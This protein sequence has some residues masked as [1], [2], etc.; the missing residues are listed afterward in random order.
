MTQVAE[1]RNSLSEHRDSLLRSAKDAQ[2]RA[3]TTLCE[4]I[5]GETELPAEMLPEVIAATGWTIDHVTQIFDRLANRKKA[6]ESFATADELDAEV[7]ELKAT[8]GEVNREIAEENR[9]HDEAM[10][11]LG[12]RLAELT[13]SVNMKMRSASSIRVDARDFLSRTAGDGDATY[14]WRNA[15]TEFIAGGIRGLPLLG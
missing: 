6:S 2:T 3:L 13:Q 4:A 5:N 8:L 7:A 1:I 15:S 12:E 9:R 10:K 11:A 14:D